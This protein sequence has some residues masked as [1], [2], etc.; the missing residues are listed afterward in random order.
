MNT[1]QL[2]VLR[3]RSGFDVVESILPLQLFRF[4]TFELSHFL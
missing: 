2:Q 3:F 1:S 4:N